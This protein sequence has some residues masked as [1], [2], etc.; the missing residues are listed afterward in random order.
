M[1]CTDDLEVKLSVADDR[2]DPI[3]PIAGVGRKRTARYIAF[4]TDPKEVEPAVVQ[5]R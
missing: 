1:A 4:L 5:A 3:T 2:H